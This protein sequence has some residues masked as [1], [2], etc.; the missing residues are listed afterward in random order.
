[1][2]ASFDSA[3]IKEFKSKLLSKH[4]DSTPNGFIYSILGSLRALLKEENGKYVWKRNPFD[5]LDK[6]GPTLV[7]TTIERSRSLGNYP[8]SVGNDS[9]NWKTLYM[10]VAFDLLEQ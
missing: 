7:G 8:Q 5:M 10:L 6:L 1:M 9:G 4:L 2:L 3:I